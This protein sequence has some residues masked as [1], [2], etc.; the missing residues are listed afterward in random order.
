MVFLTLACNGIYA[1]T[2]KQVYSKF[3]RKTK[4][5]KKKN[6]KNI[7]KK[8]KKNFKKREDQ[9]RRVEMQII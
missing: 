8:K 6:K 7:K 9:L 3:I 5:K 1:G 4:R 2:K